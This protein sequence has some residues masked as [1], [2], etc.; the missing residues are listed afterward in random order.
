MADF[1]IGLGTAWFENS[2]STLHMVRFNAKRNLRFK[3][4]AC[5]FDASV[6]KTQKQHL[7]LFANILA[8]RYT[9]IA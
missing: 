9:L 8:L 6:R 4:T 1:K 5:D 7:G 2:S 3:G